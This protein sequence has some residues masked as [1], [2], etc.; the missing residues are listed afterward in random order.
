VDWRVVGGLLVAGG[1]FN[2]A[3][4]QALGVLVPD[5]AS[6]GFQVAVFLS[7]VLTGVVASAT[8]LS[9]IGEQ[10]RIDRAL[11]ILEGRRILRQLFALWAV[12]GVLLLTRRLLLFLDFEFWTYVRL[13]APWISE[14]A[15]QF[16][17]PDFSKFTTYSIENDK[18]GWSGL[19]GTIAYV[20]P[21]FVDIVLGRTTVATES[22]EMVNGFGMLLN[23][24]G[25][26]STLLGKSVV[27]VIIGFCGTVLGFP[28]ALLFG[29]LGSERVT[30]FPFNFIFRGTMSTIRAIPALVWIYILIAL[31]NISQAGAVLAIAIDT[32]GNMGR[33]FTDELEEI[34][35][36]PI[37]AMRS[38]GGSRSQVV[39][40]G[41][42]SQVTT[43]FIAWALYI[44]E[45]NVRI[46]ISLGIVGAGGIG[47]YISGRFAVFDYG[48]G[49]AG[50]FMVIIIVISVEL[51]STRI[52]ARLRPEEHDSKGLLDI[53]RGLTDSQKWF[54]TGVQKNP[55]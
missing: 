1:G 25:S 28:F 3:V 21:E 53:L 20:L 15:T 55:D 46:A 24:F 47:Q 54:G 6:P 37:E 39:S 27:T 32:I 50:L 45:I 38:T 14:Y 4:E 12:F 33:L 29:V 40:F 10:G 43:S 41:M 23:S 30:P 5:A 35:E 18:T 51:L 49:G 22:N 26:N 7:V 52:R 8:R 2:L 34:E 13:F 11:E 19:F 44:L 17:Q 9:T 16:L 48:E 42:L 31:T 36:G